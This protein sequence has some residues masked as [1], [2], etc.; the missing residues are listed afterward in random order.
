MNDLLEETQNFIKLLYGWLHN[1]PL[2]EN[3]RWEDMYRLAKNHGL[4]TIFYEIARN[5]TDC[6]EEVKQAAKKQYQMLINQQIQQEY[7]AEELFLKLKEAKIPYA[8]L[9]G[10]VLRRLYPSPELRTSC[11]VDVLYDEARKKDVAPI[12]RELGF[13]LNGEW[14]NGVVTIEMH[15]ELF[16]VNE[17]G[18]E[19]YRTVWQKLRTDDG[20]EYRFTD[21]DF[22]IYFLAHAA[23][24]LTGAGFGVRTV[25]DVY[26]FCREKPALDRAYLQEEL[27]KLGL[28][29]FAAT[30]EKLSRV[31]FDG[32]SADE[33]TELLGEY[34]FGSGTY[35]QT[36]NRALMKGVEKN[37]SV[38][39][40]KRRYIFKTLFPSYNDMVT[41]YPFLKKAPFLLPFMW[42]YK[43]FEVL[44]KRRG[45][46]R[47]TV[48]NLRQMQEAEVDLAKKVL[49]ITEISNE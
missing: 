34:I 12:M 43:W 9:K 11:D 33:E 44:F 16:A 5:E 28:A 25:L 45:K 1:A 24:H 46:F 20:A 37:N 36:K 35:G 17:R 39:K 38:G 48:E 29:K 49:E 47:Q 40:S 18:Y 32:E 22:Y 6:P 23:K 31:W 21:E 14:M 42:I 30:M 26:I 4:S 7:Y 3:V 10:Y 27:S 13:C 19:Y 15:H 41:V 8:P 2:P